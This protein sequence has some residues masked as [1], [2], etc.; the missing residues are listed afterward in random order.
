M[1]YQIL[2]GKNAQNNW[3]II[4]SAQPDDIWFH[5]GDGYASSHIILHINDKNISSIPAKIIFHCAQLCKHHSRAKNIK[6]IKV[7]YCKVKNLKKGK[8]IGSVSCCKTKQLYV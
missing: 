7:I 5:V 6:K 1:D 4:S 8:E 3:D 2:I